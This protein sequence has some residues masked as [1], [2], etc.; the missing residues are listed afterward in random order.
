MVAVIAALL[1]A[2]VLVAALLPGCEQR[3]ATCATSGVR[4]R[5]L[6][7]ERHSEITGALRRLDPVVW[8][9]SG[10]HCKRP[11]IVFSHGHYGDPSSCSR[12]CARLARA[13]FLVVAVR[14][15]DRRTVRAQQAPERVD[16]VAYVIEHLR[17]RYDHRRVGVAGHSFGGVTALQYA[18]QFPRVRAVL[19][20]AG[21]ADQGTMRSLEVPTLL[22]AG[23]EDTLEPPDIGATAARA[24]PASVPHRLVVVPGARHGD[25]ID[26]CARIRRCGF[27]GRTAVAFFLTYL[28]RR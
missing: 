28:A 27:V 12:L 16:D 17:L 4:H 14:H 2:L 3:R 24:I 22:M 9:P 13:G 26:G 6:H 8:A 21:T 19:A 10:G 23:S 15:R 5:M 25:L 20:M 18:S 11:L 7:L 1:L